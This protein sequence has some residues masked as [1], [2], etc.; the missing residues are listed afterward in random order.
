MKPKLDNWES[1]MLFHAEHLIW[2]GRNEKAVKKDFYIKRLK[3]F[4]KAELKA[5]D[6]EWERRIRKAIPERRGFI[7][8]A[9]RV[10]S[11]LLQESKK[12]EGVKT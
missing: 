12:V 6:K 1:E 4:I 8:T 7:P 3:A 5:R 9:E 11:D 10:L 2:V